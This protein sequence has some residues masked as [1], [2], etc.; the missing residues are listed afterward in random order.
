[1]AEY[2]V[3]FR[4]PLH[5]GSKIVKSLNRAG[6][7]SFNEISFFRSVNMS[8]EEVVEHIKVVCRDYGD[9]PRFRASAFSVIPVQREQEA[10]Q[11]SNVQSSRFKAQIS[12]KFKASKS[13]SARSNHTAY[14]YV[15]SGGTNASGA[16]TVIGQNGG[17]P[18]GE[19]LQ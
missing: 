5:P 16:V 19:P 11:N 4:L 2:L 6:W 18:Q 9:L 3:L 1:M 15:A 8:H 14:C 13:N 10:E 17:H 7:R 12:N